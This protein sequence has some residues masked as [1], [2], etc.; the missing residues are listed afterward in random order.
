[1]SELSRDI[2][3]YHYKRPN[4][5]GE[6]FCVSCREP[7]PCSAIRAAEEIERLEAALDTAVSLMRQAFVHQPIHNCYE[8][9]VFCGSTL[10]GGKHERDCEGV[11]WVRRARTLLQNRAPDE[12]DGR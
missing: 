11:A 5:I 3:R 9:C 7:H 1:V 6:G 2:H 10:E 12:G 8:S 4:G